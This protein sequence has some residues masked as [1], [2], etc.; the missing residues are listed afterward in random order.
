M[1]IQRHPSNKI[2]RA[3]YF[4][5]L[6]LYWGRM[7]TNHWQNLINHLSFRWVTSPS[8]IWML[9]RTVDFIMVWTVIWP[10]KPRFSQ[11]YLELNEQTYG[12][13]VMM[14][15]TNRNQ[16]QHHPRHAHTHPHLSKFDPEKFWFSLATQKSTPGLKQKPLVHWTIPSRGLFIISWSN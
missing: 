1:E 15:T 10:T 16:V 11:L 13:T 4:L 2:V 9:Y 5:F 14:K 7:L 12:Q 6:V 3:Y 8:S